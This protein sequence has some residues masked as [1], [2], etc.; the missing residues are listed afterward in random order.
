MKK[1][2]LATAL[3]VALAS[4]AFAGGKD[5]M[6]ED[7]KVALK[8][9]NAAFQTTESYKK[10]SFT[11]NGKSVNAYFDAENEDLI[12]FGLSID[13]NDLPQGTM[14]NISKKYQDWSVTNAILFIDSKGGSAYYVQVNKDKHSLALS[15]SP[16]GK[17]NIYAKMPN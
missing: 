17:V 10:A 5:K 16:K 4:A 6:L 8:S 9:S 3:F 12:G 11:F 15:V 7:L 2:V 1:I 13:V 14:E